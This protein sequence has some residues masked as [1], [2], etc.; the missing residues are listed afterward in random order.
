MKYYAKSKKKDVSVTEQAKL[1]CLLQNIKEKL[2]KQLNTE[3]IKIIDRAI[4]TVS[5]RKFEEKQKLLSEHENDILKCAG[6][7]FNEYG[8]YFSDK[9]KK[10][11]LEACKIHDWGKAN[12][13]FQSIVQPEIKSSN[14]QQVSQI[15]HGYLSAITISQTEFYEI[16]ERFTEKDFRAFLTAVYHHHVREDSCEPRNIREFGKKYY[17][18]E[19]S[20]YL[21]TDRK[22]LYCSNMDKLLFR[23]QAYSKNICTETDVWNEYLLIKGML[24]KFDYTVSAGY[25][26]AENF[27]DKTKKRLSRNIKNALMD[28]PLRPVQLFMQQHP[29][30][31]LIITAP[32]GSGKTE[33]ALLWLNGEK[34]FY[35]LPLKVSSNA[36]YSRIK[37]K[38]AYE[39]VS[40]LHSDSMVLYLKEETE[41]SASERLEQAK[42]L[43][44]PLTVC[45]IDQL[46]RFVYKAPGT[47]IFA[48]TLKYSK[49]IIDEIQSY[50]AKSIATIIYGLKTLHEM[51]GKFAIITATF[52]PVLH[53]FMKQ[54]GLI[55]EK[56]YLLRDFTK[57]DKQIRHKLHV[58]HGDFDLVEISSR[59]KSKKVLVI[60]NTVAKAQKVYGDLL[61]MDIPVWLLHSKFI[62]KDR[63]ILEQKI[64]DFSMFS[65]EKT[66]VWVTTQ[67]VEA[68]LDIDFGI[69]YTEM[70]PADSLLQRIGRCNRK[71]RY[72]PDKP[73]VFVYDNRNGVGKKSV[74]DPFLYERSLE[75]LSKYTDAPFS[76][77]EK[78]QFVCEVYDAESI[79]DSGYYQEIQKYLEMFSQIQPADYCL[80]EAKVRDIKSVSV[81]PDEVYEENID[82]FTVGISVLSQ[83]GI[84]KDVKELIQMKLQNLTLSMNLYSHF[85]PDGVDKMTIDARNGRSVLDIHRTSYTYDFHA[86]KGQ[87]KGLVFEKKDAQIFL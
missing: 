11:I 33:A 27:C 64:M 44:Y 72:V 81:I 58:T 37:E 29:D 6:L 14:C 59:A 36:I 18:K 60:C 70:C 52:P 43:T 10:L 49:L 83:P 46:F 40:L 82:L 7:F 19:I 38:Y 17:L 41:V 13:V 9:E 8:S 20:E 79:C 25:A 24:N 35:T 69:L 75:F 30:D 15:P 65:T 47:E 50:D 85:L 5:Q 67:I 84:P 48:A 54:Y 66:G 74:Y 23:N 77:S 71:G 62:R 80:K 1:V 51:G 12:L 42:L 78:T 63:S 28:Y 32:T 22:K 73:N 34:G 53:Y 2:S 76:E 3:E 68:S 87:G 21:K 45:T 39:N 16:D 55:Q 26:S 86:D 4:A 56:D 61:Q 31:N 57:E